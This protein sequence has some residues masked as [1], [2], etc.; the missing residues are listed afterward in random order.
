[1]PARQT[2]AFA[3]L[4]PGP[5]H[6]KPAA[7]SARTAPTST[8]VVGVPRFAAPLRPSPAPA[9]LPSTLP[10]PVHAA[11]QS[12]GQSLAPGIRDDMEARLGHDLGS[13]RVHTDPTAAASAAA[14]QARA[15]TVANHIVFGAGAYSPQTDTG[16]Q[17]LTHELVHTLQQRGAATLSSGPL[18]VTAPQDTSELEADRIARNLF[19]RRPNRAS[20]PSGYSPVSVTPA[21]LQLAREAAPGN[22]TFA[23][24]TLP[25][26][27]HLAKELLRHLPDGP[28]FL[29]GLAEA[30][31]L[32]E[33]RGAGGPPRLFH[34]GNPM[35]RMK[36][37]AY[38]R[39]GNDWVVEEI[40]DPTPYAGRPRVVLPEMPHIGDLALALFRQRR[41]MTWATDD[42]AV[43]AES[44]RQDDQVKERA[45]YRKRMVGVVAHRNF[46][47]LQ[48]KQELQKR[49]ATVTT[50]L[51]F[52]KE[53]NDAYYQTR[54]EHLA[55][56]GPVP[57]IGGVNA[58]QKVLMELIESGKV[59]THTGQRYDEHFGA[60]WD[61]ARV[62]WARKHPQRAEEGDRRQRLEAGLQAIADIS[63]TVNLSSPAADYVIDLIDSIAMLY[64]TAAQ[65]ILVNRAEAGLQRLLGPFGFRVVEGSGVGS[66]QQQRLE[67][68]LLNYRALQPRD[69]ERL[70]RNPGL[71][72]QY[73][74]NVYPTREE[75]EAKDRLV[76]I[77]TLPDGTLHTGSLAEF[78]WASDN[79][80]IL[81]ALAQLNAIRNSGPGSLIGR[82]F[83][84]EKGAA[85]G[86]MADAGLM[87]RAPMNA[88]RNI[89]AQ[90]NAGSTGGPGSPSTG[91]SAP[92][93]PL[94]HRAPAPPR[95]PIPA[96]RPTRLGETE[97]VAANVRHQASIRVQTPTQ[98]QQSWSAFGGEGAAPL[99][100]RHAGNT[101]YLSS[102]SRL[103]APATRS[104]NPPFPPQS[105]PPAPTPPAP[106]TPTPPAPKPAVG[107]GK[108]DIGFDKT[109]EIDP[110][111]QTPPGPIPAPKV[112]PPGNAPP[113]PQTAGTG[114][115]PKFR[116]HPEVPPQP[117]SQATLQRLQHLVRYSV[118]SERHEQ[119]WALLNGRGDAPPAFISE[120]VIYVD[121][122]RPMPP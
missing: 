4:A 47:Q 114:P 59:V 16:R 18:P 100:Y 65:V 110:L 91:S 67:Y 42:P 46:E 56:V 92:L 108:P 111:A 75:L 26:K 85:I 1:M 43:L 118:S 5:G 52:E 30:G 15:Y 64:G 103:V 121:A 9:A 28:G 20:P 66:L 117:V 38:V 102:A 37:N 69:R 35:V 7:V 62:D 72:G 33:F 12:A 27:L 78:R 44:V 8:P 34:L 80:R 3:P 13:V 106:K 54:V 45:D 119:A 76:A 36:H 32:I 41:Q 10:L 81:H 90:M 73:G 29:N 2:H 97:V 49:G 83:G 112:A 94:A 88:R 31:G 113:G 93:V 99:A 6:A 122:T 55:G 107:P 79:N 11:V 53:Y 24:G 70:R 39:D 74:I 25:W 58:G 17:L 86:A 22:P 63:L 23:I 87:I 50:P 68:A 120:R 96:P 116:F 105:P 77:R 61:Q 60:A 48:L 21:S 109:G 51:P 14:V 40:T 19:A 98:H 115:R 95:V 89:R 82:I 104:G 84:G 57:K 101:V 71:A